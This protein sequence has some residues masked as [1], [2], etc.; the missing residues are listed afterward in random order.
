MVYKFTVLANPTYA[1]TLTVY[2]VISLPEIH[3]VSPLYIYSGQPYTCSGQPASIL[4]FLWYF[5]LWGGA[6]SHSHFTT[7]YDPWNSE[8]TQPWI[9]LT[10]LLREKKRRTTQAGS[11]H[12]SPLWLRKN[13][14]CAQGK[15][16]SRAKEKELFDW[17]KEAISG[18]HLAVVVCSCGVWCTI[19]TRCYRIQARW[20][21][22]MSWI[23]I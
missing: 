7:G 6:F 10:S 19:L 4:F 18:W 15:R 2:L 1:W 9:P 12:L 13:S 17:G 3:Q 20:L 23:S 11:G 8:I 14:L 21:D 16:A 22:K 5:D